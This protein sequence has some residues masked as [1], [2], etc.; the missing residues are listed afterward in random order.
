MSVDSIHCIDKNMKKKTIWTPSEW[1]TI[2]RNSRSNV[3]QYETIILNY[4][5][6][7]NWNDIC[8]AT[9]NKAKLKDTMMFNSS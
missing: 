7:L 9:F 2:I 8:N 4:K 1:P 3:G 5:D 6:F